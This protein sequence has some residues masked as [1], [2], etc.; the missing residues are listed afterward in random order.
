MPAPDA[1][2]RFSDRVEYYIRSRPGYPEG[3]VDFL[4]ETTNLRSGAAIADVGSGTGLSSELFLRRG[5]TVYGVEPNAAMRT[6]AERLLAAYP[7]FRSVAATAEA[8][9]LAATSVDL[10]IAG[11]AFHWFDRAAARCEFARIARSPSWTALLW[12]TRRV[13][14]TPFG[15]AYEALVREFST[16]YTSVRHENIAADE[17]QAFFDP[18]TYRLQKFEN[19]QLL[20]LAGFQAR[21]LSSSYLPG[22]G[23]PRRADMLAAAERL[24]IDHRQGGRIRLEYD[25]EVHLGCVGR[26]AQN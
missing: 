6:A 4:T 16:D 10:I 2:A 19:V 9:T 13:D 14:D 17:L 24:F 20:D 18:G 3:V 1:T 22:D 23:H 15:Q 21:L 11:Q 8:T 7:N 5:Y 12:N 25:S 26:A